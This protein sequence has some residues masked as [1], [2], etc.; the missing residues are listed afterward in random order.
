MLYFGVDYYPEHWPEGR[1]AEDAR[2]MAE[3]GFNVVRLAEFAWALLEPAEGT[4]DFGWLDR[5]IALLAD[6]GMQVVLGTPTASPPPWLMA[7]DP[8][9]FRVLPDGRRVEFGL[10]REYC[11]NHPGYHEAARRIVSRMAEHYGQHLAVIGWQIDNEFGDRCYCPICRAA[12]QTWLQRRYRTLDAVNQRWGTAFWSHRYTAWNQ[13][14]VPS[15][16]AW[17]PNPG[18][19]LDYA[20]FCSDSYVAFQQQQIDLLR[21]LSPGRFITHNFMGFRYDQVNYFDLARPLDLIAWDNY[22]RN[23]WNAATLPDPAAPAL[24]HDTMYGLKQQPFWVME[25]QAGPAGWEVTAPTPRPGELRLWAHQ[26]IAHGADGVVFFRWRT[27]RVG[28]EQNWHGLLDHHGRPGRRYEEVRRLGTE[29]KAIGARVVGTRP[30]PQIGLLLSYDSRFALQILPHVANFSY[31]EHV[32]EVYRALH[33][34]HVPSAVVAPDADFSRYRLLIAPAL[35]VLDEMTAA[36][37]RRFVEAG[38]VL[39]VTACSGVK[40]DANRVV[41]QPRPGLLAELCGV[42]VEEYDALPPGKTNTVC[43]TSGGAAA[44]EAFEVDTWCEILQPRGAQVLAEYQ[45]DYYAGRAA[46]ARH[47]FGAGEAVYCGVF[48]GASLMAALLRRLIAAANV[49]PLLPEAP[50]LEVVERHGDG[51][52]LLFVLNHAAEPR[53]LSLAAEYVNLLEGAPAPREVQVGAHDVVILA[54]QEPNRA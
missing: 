39:L 34:L 49:A 22:P 36:N 50:D 20:R 48:G 19:G 35:H 9:L 46:I 23:Q 27:A 44:G 28:A 42:E 7:R 26:A 33:R 3:A 32:G 52:T 13:I 41:E 10:R 16:T 8:S 15:T 6:H 31:S 37:L 24:A 25:E 14:P 21:P 54:L 5:A 30:A 4:F 43:F 40:D 1:W 18:L 29:I 53:T 45:Q 38:G 17:P 51:R 12:F 11:P 47:P 2:L